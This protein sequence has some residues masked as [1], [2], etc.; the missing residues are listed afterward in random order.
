MEDIVVLRT[1]WHNVYKLTKMNPASV[2]KWL[3]L[4]M[5]LYVVVPRRSSFGS[6]TSAGLVVPVPTADCLDSK[7][8]PVDFTELKAQLSVK[9]IKETTKHSLQ[10]I[11][12]DKTW[13]P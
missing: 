8:G 4:G 13:Y 11:C 12:F 1:R 7:N 9:S 5:L 3:G 2:S 6:D 10:S